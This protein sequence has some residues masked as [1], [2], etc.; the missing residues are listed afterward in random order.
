MRLTTSPRKKNSIVQEPNRDKNWSDL[1]ERH[2]RGKGLKNEIWMAT[3]NVL[4]L[5]EGGP[6]EDGCHRLEDT[7]TQKDGCHRLEDTCTQ[8]RRLEDG[9]EGGQGPTK[10]GEPLSSLVVMNLRVQ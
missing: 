3:W 10:T 2:G 7:C 4:S 9:R 1:L 8:K 6:E 5:R